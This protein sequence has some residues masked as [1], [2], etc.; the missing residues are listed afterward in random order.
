MS[1]I[2]RSKTELVAAERKINKLS[3]AYLNGEFDGVTGGKP[4]PFQWITFPEYRTGFCVGLTEFYNKK[5]EV[6]A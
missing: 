1:N 6:V 5:F 3:G 4:D 2:T